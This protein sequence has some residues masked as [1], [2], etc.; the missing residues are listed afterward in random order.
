MIIEEE[1]KQSAFFPGEDGSIT[2]GQVEMRPD[3]NPNVGWV[4][5]WQELMENRSLVLTRL[6]KLN[7]RLGR[8]TGQEGQVEIYRELGEVL[9]SICQDFDLENNI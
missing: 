4:K 2:F 6:T 3:G 5:R 7:E 9:R 1:P 8:A